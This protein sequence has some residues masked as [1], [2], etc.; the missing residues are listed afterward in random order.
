MAKVHIVIEDIPES[1]QYVMV[2]Y[3]KEPRDPMEK[4]TYA[5][6]VGDEIYAALQEIIGEHDQNTRWGITQ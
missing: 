3:D 2:R 5:E 4:P 1:E 6:R